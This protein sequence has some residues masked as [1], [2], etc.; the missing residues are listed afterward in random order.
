MFGEI[1]NILI[2]PSLVYIKFFPFS[3]HFVK[4]SK[5]EGPLLLLF[6]DNVSHCEPTM[7]RQ[8]SVQNVLFQYGINNT[9]YTGL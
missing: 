5:F 3:T 7:F 1:I 4:F 6:V 9:I 2:S 8:D